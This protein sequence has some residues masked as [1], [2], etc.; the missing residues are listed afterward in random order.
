MPAHRQVLEPRTTRQMLQFG[1]FQ[2]LYQHFELGHRYLDLPPT[3]PS[4]LASTDL[5]PSKA[6]AL[7]RL[8]DRS[9]VSSTS[10][11]PR[12]VRPSVQSDQTDIIGAEHASSARSGSQSCLRKVPL[13]SPVS[14]YPNSVPLCSLVWNADRTS[15]V[16]VPLGIMSVFEPLGGILSA[17]LPVTYV[18]FANSF[19]K[20]RETFSSTFS[21][22]PRGRLSQSSNNRFARGQDG[23]D[24]W[25]Q[26][27]QPS[28]AT[29]SKPML[30]GP[31]SQG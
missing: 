22:S 26:L 7:L 23:E 16:G 27:D 29:D 9:R 19:R 21:K 15:G 4:H 5:Q 8:S 14:S 30:H 13:T 31:N 24:R 12:T 1:R 10:S 3:H 25:I 20:I 6:R 2:L 11:S 18:L 17:N 28:W